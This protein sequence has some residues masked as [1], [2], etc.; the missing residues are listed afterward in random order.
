MIT[1]EQYSAWLRDANAE[2]VILVEATHSTGTVYV[3]S[4]AYQTGQGETPA[5][6]CYR[7]VMANSPEIVERLGSA[8]VGD[9]DLVN[10]GS[11]DSWL[12]LYWRGYPLQ[13]YLGDAGWVRSDFRLAVDAINGGISRPSSGRLQWTIYD[14]AETIRVPV[15][16]ESNPIRLGSVFNA[17]AV[18]VDGV[19]LKYKAH[20]NPAT[21][22]T[23][24]DNGV[25]VT[26][27]SEDL[28]NAEFTLSQPPVG[29]ITVDVEQED[30]TA[31]EMITHLCG[32]KGI[33]VDAAN[34]TAFANTD[35]LGLSIS[36]EMTLEE[37]LTQFQTIGAQI[38]FDSLGKLQIYRLD[39]PQAAQATF[40]LTD[41]DMVADG[42][43][44]ESDEP[45]VTDYTVGYKRN[46]QV[47][48][49]DSLG[50]GLTAIDRDLYS[51][52]YST[53]T[54][55]NAVSDY[56]LA[57]N[58]R[59]DTLL[60]TQAGAQSEC[61]RLAGLRNTRRRVWKAVCF[62]SSQTVQLGDVVN[63]QHPRWGFDN[64]RAALVI[65]ITSRLGQRRRELYLW[66]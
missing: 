2:P 38:R 64:G 32:L 47:Q 62:L 43:S 65:G 14:R 18:L 5:H 53:V 24:R 59:R 57:Q 33:S 34:L 19:T 63:V 27:A 54:V 7:A 37:A 39:E 35:T 51:T 11:L 6:T 4:Q 10:D 20:S 52:E 30:Q 56:P 15:G 22:M 31:A 50:D 45:P 60:A 8:T 3:A 41:A 61:N 13:L 36:H 1:D 21:S 55:T 42:F 23:V 17:K 26:L 49:A 25:A 48:S 29:D 9:M 44:M 40:T 16:S 12:D 58:R 66:L 46:W 28:T